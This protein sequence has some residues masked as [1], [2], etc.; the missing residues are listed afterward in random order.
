[1]NLI[2]YLYFLKNLLVI[3]RIVH[4]SLKKKK[5]S[6]IGCLYILTIFVELL[7]NKATDC[8]F[9]VFIHN[10][11]PNIQV[12]IFLFKNLIIHSTANVNTHC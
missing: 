11:D 12:N 10:N 6:F 5:E 4:W 1:M 3:Y 2:S 9:G 7:P 8:H